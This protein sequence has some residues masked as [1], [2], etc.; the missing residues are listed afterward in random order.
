M[1]IA[2][3]L[4]EQRKLL[5]VV[6][7]LLVDGRF[8]LLGT[9]LRRLG[10][11]HDQDVLPVLGGPFFD[12]AAAVVELDVGLGGPPLGDQQQLF[13]ELLLVRPVDPAGGRRL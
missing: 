2:A 9:R 4:V 6:S 13:V 1:G 5:T 8:L 12:A 11:F 3:L 7:P 10:R